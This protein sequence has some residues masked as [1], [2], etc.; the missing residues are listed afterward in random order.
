VGK[1][2]DRGSADGITRR[3]AERALRKLIGERIAG[4]RR[5]PTGSAPR[6]ATI[7]EWLYAPLLGSHD[8]DRL[9]N[10]L[11]EEIAKGPSRCAAPS[12]SSRVAA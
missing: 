11:H 3:D 12:D 1:V 10:R 2:R 4:G 9:E 7:G 8:K 6:W 5:R